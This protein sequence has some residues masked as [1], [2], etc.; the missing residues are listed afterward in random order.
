MVAV[1]HGAP[2]A[3][4]LG[5]TDAARATLAISTARA[6]LVISATYAMSAACAAWAVQS[7]AAGWVARAAWAINAAR[8]AGAMCAVRVVFVVEAL[9][10]SR[11]TKIGNIFLKRCPIYLL[12]NFQK[13]SEICRS[14]FDVISH[15]I[16]AT[17]AT[18]RHCCHSF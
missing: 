12:D 11:R 10:P 16:V 18:W 3:W 6:A 17:H 1:V 8:E 13:M 7:M 4:A 9:R 14:E 5:A 15:G 2:A